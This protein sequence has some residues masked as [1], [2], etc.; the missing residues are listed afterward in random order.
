M[1]NIVLFKKRKKE[2]ELNLM[3]HK[4]HHGEGSL[5]PALTWWQHEVH[6]IYL[7]T[8]HLG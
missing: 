5:R 8:Q 2:K 4:V 1:N 7:H 6:I 3:C